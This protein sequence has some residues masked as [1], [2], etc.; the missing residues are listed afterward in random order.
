M[1]AVASVVLLGAHLVAWLINTS[2]DLRFDPDWATS[3]LTTTVGKIELWRVG[4][5]ILA[6]WAWWLARRPRLALAFA[7]GALIVSGA[8]G[9]SAAIQPV[10]GVPS[11]AKLPFISS[12]NP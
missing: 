3:A 12:R 1:F 11:K 7:A 9:H 2:P 6:L 4:L 10:W 8:V 5:T